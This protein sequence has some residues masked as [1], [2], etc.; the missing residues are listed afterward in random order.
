MSIGKELVHARRDGRISR[1]RFGQL[2]AALGVGVVT[3]PVLARPARA[4]GEIT[5]FGWSGYEDPNFHKGYIEKYGG[6]PNFS[7]WG[8]EDEAFNK[9]M[10]GYDPDVVA[11]CTYEVPQWV[12][13]GVV[14]P[15]DESRL[16]HLADMFSSVTDIPGTRIDGKRYFVPMDWGNSTVVY[17][18]DMIDPEYIKENSWKVLFD[19]RY[20]GR[21][22]TFDDNVNVEIAG[23]L[24]GYDNI[25]SMTDE[26]LA[27]A[28]KLLEKQREVLRF[29]WTDKTQIEQALA[30]GE[31]IAAYSWNETYVGLRSQGVPVGFMVPKEGIFTWCCGLMIHAKSKDLDASYELINA[32]TSPET[33]AYEIETWGYGH[34]NKKAFAMVAEEKLKELNLSTPEALLDAGIFFQPL[35]PAIETKYI[36]LLE[37]VKGGV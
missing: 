37:E 24:L 7:F 19:E 34:A 31:L 8:S 27:E 4:E 2:A 5:Y 9:L 29:Y 13:G 36:Q 28:R 32:M 18:T 25:F 26:Q 14:Q 22:A 11:P 15:V 20:K 17:R 30:S 12:G 33:G 16:T 1:R 35:D 21:V 10:A 3:M 6:S 23:L